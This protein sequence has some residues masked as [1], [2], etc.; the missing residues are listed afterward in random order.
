VTRVPIVRKVAAAQPA[1]APSLSDAW[2]AIYRYPSTGVM[3]PNWVLSTAPPDGWLAG[4]ATPPG[5]ADPP[6]YFP[7]GLRVDL[8][9]NNSAILNNAQSR[10]ANALDGT[11][12]G[13][14][15]TNLWAQ[16][17]QNV[18]REAGEVGGVYA[19]AAAAMASTGTAIGSAVATEAGTLATAAMTD[20]L[21]AEAV[22]WLSGLLTAIVND[23]ITALTLTT[24]TTVAGASALGS[25]VPVLG[26]VIG[27]VVGAIVGL[28][29]FMVGG[30]TVQV[31]NGTTVKC[32]DYVQTNLPDAAAFLGAQ[33]SVVGMTPRFLA[34]A[35]SLFLANP[36][37]LT[38][39]EDN[40]GRHWPTPP[41]MGTFSP[42]DSIYTKCPGA[43]E[44]LNVYQFAEA[45]ALVSS[46]PSKLPFFQANAWE[47]KQRA[48]L[49]AKGLPLSLAVPPP[50]PF[51]TQ[52][53]SA[54]NPYQ[55][56]VDGNDSNNYEGWGLIAWAPCDDPGPNYVYAS[57]LNLF[58][59]TN[60]L[61]GGAPDFGRNPRVRVTIQSQTDPSPAGNGLQGMYPSLTTRQCNKLCAATY[62]A[63]VQ[64]FAAAQAWMAGQ[65][66]GPPTP[67]DLGSGSRWNLTSVDVGILL[68]GWPGTPGG[69]QWT[70]NIAKGIA[71]GQTSQGGAAA[72]A[73]QTSSAFGL[74]L[75]AAAP[76]PPPMVTGIR[77]SAPGFLQTPT[78]TL[79]QAHQII[80]QAPTNPAAAGYV[81]ATVASAN[82]GH[83]A[84]VA[85][86]KVLS[87]AQRLQI[88]AAYVA[89]YV[90][91][92]QAAAVAK[93]LGMTVPMQIP[94]GTGR[95]DRNLPLYLEQTVTA[96]LATNRDPSQLAQLARALYP[97]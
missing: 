35:F 49:A 78:L 15:V 42:V 97:R 94:K 58:S 79:P 3:A 2:A 1:A 39:N 25:V 10:I 89:K 21:G 13:D 60:T 8:T 76:S 66:S 17:E 83:P 93:G 51:P 33:T 48:A 69:A 74:A 91:P 59:N 80:A 88:Q 55:F 86:A 30:P 65:S 84:G 56:Q 38:I 28:V 47:A 20:L 9:R 7:P 18:L 54:W 36:V 41:D 16:L 44:L 52:D 68:A 75:A 57:C 24:A 22:T 67:A 26:T 72:A 64:N 29:D 61:V 62:P 92:K 6:P 19:S 53:R 11:S 14:S 27:A 96:M 90:G 73:S 85:A 46:S 50:P 71:R 32:K 63:Y 82:A 12:L 81:A 31:T 4:A 43:Y 23:V 34:D 77:I 45:A 5:P 40:F 95:Y 37:W 70:A 87:L